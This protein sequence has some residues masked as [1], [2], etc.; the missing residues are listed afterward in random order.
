MRIHIFQRELSCNALL[1]AESAAMV[2]L[3]QEAFVGQ[4]VVGICTEI[5]S[6][7]T[8]AYEVLKRT[9]KS[10]GLVYEVLFRGHLGT[11]GNPGRR[12]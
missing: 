3:Q 7:T 1:A 2:N 5:S 9:I 4:K 8:E 12:S 10:L 6:A 11:M